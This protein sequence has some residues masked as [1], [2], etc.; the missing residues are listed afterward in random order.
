MAQAV[1]GNLRQ[2]SRFFANSVPIF[3]AVSGRDL[4]ET[5]T[6]VIED[7]LEDIKDLVN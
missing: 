3:S 2:M 4:K 5:T 7:T 1:K 6:D